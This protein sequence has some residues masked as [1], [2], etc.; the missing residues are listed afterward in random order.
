MKLIYLADSVIPSRSA[1]SVHVMKMC[2]AFAAAGHA[3]HLVVPDKKESQLD[4]VA[5]V[6]AFYGVEPSFAVHRVVWPHVPK[7]GRLWAWYAARYAAELR[8]DIVYGRSP[9][10]CL[11]AADAGLPVVFEEHRFLWKARSRAPR[12]SHLLRGGIEGV[13]AF[14][15][16]QLRARRSPNAAGH[17]ARP[18]LAVYRDLIRN[19]GFA[20]ADYLFE[21]LCTHPRLV[22]FITITH[23]LKRD[24]VD[25]YPEIANRITVAP[26]GADLAPAQPAADICLIAGQG[27]VQVGYCG[28]FFPGKG[29]E[30]IEDLVPLCP[31][32]DFHIVGG[33]EPELQAW[34][35]RLGR[36]ANIH[37]YG[38]VE[39]HV[40]AAYIHR[41][42]IC[43][44]P[45]QPSVQ[46]R[47]QKADIGP[48]TSPLKMFEY[49]AAGK[50]IIAS[51]LDVLKEILIHN[52]NSLLCPYDNPAAW[53]D[54][55]KQL[56]EQPERGRRIGAQ[57]KLDLAAFYT[58]RARADRVLANAPPPFSAREA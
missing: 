22:R 32:A 26:D 6:F 46:T 17:G 24:I 2:Q 56:V 53:A 7:G 33:H 4:N 48:Y 36:H 55:L 5:D 16:S 20:S 52:H 13:G 35:T 19:G 15:R 57:A 42:D 34:R 51:D 11:H 38:Y 9:K 8:P 40:A 37:F 18:P 27:A 44:L 54:T 12:A 45:N 49:M 39:P 21:R 1:N 30:L 10:A 25:T 58:W 14:V 23:A 31:W 29:M 50:P 47:S 43:L 3:V 28:Q 41:F